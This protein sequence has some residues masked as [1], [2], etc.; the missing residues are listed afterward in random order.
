MI[1]NVTD[2]KKK[3]AAHITLMRTMDAL[4]LSLFKQLKPLLNRQFIDTAR[5]IKRTGSTHADLHFIINK[6]SKRL[7]TM[8]KRHYTRTASTFLKL[9]LQSLDDIGLKS[10]RPHETKAFKEEE[11]WKNISAWAEST[12]ASKIVGLQ[13][14]SANQIARIIRQGLEAGDSNAAVARRILDTGNITSKVRART[15]AR[16]ETHTAAVMATDTAMKTTRLPNVSREWSTTRDDRAR[17]DHTAADGQLRDQDMPFEVGGEKLRFPGDPLGSGKNIINCRCVL[18]YHTQQLVRPTAE[19]AVVEPT[20]TEAEIWQPIMPD[21]M[22]SVDKMNLHQEFGRRMVKD[23]IGTELDDVAATIKTLEQKYKAEYSAWN[24]VH[25]QSFDLAF[26]TLAELTDWRRI[27]LDPL[28]DVYQ[29]TKD[30]IDAAKARLV[31]IMSKL[32]D[33]ILSTSTLNAAQAQKRAEVIFISGDVGT[34]EKQIRE[35]IARAARMSNGKSLRTF[36]NLLMNA[37]EDRA[38]ANQANFLISL[39]GKEKH[40]KKEILFHEM[41]HHIEFSSPIK[42]KPSAREFVRAKSTSS[43]EELLSKLTGNEKYGNEKAYPGKYYNPYIGK[44]YDD[45]ATEVVSMG[46]QK[47][48]NPKDMVELYFADKD[49][50]ELTLGMIKTKGY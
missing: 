47:F 20:L 6:Q 42:I 31:P 26:D 37:K 39:D 17:K 16:T 10:A 46:F 34:K 45:G 28:Q 22:N 5:E 43:T 24:V 18:M 27:H 44:V 48:A 11:F 3:A 7:K 2:P 36:T 9:T 8:L 21:G 1:V 38:Y 4:D 33:K 29:A 23:A 41:G 12:A 32:D 25:K 35:T 50:F 14:H 13:G 15:I 40:L 30:T 49:M 19:E